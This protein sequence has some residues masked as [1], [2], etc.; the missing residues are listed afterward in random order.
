MSLAIV[1]G[2]LATFYFGLQPRWEAPLPFAQYQS[3]EVFAHSTL[4]RLREQL[5]NSSLVLFGIEPEESEHL[6]VLHHLLHDPDGLR[7]DH[8]IADQ[9]LQ[10]KELFP[11]AEEMDTQESLSLLLEELAPRLGQKQKVAIILPT[12]YSSQLIPGNMASLLKQQLH[13]DPI[14]LSMVTFP[15]SRSEEKKMRFPCSVKDVDQ[16]GLGE[17]GCAIVQAARPLYSQK[18]TSGSLIGLINQVGEKDYLVLLRK[19]P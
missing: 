18:M 11:E 10:A 16:T 14:S 15:R 4:S 3:P 12:V 5:Q 1:G 2:L 7:F 9:Y 13:F 8:V 17:L 19:E 6:K